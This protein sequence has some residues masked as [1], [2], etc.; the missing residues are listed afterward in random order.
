M[1]KFDYSDNGFTSFFKNNLTSVVT[2]IGVFVTLSLG[3][4]TYL[5]DRTTIKIAQQKERPLACIWY[6]DNTDSA[7]V[8]LENKGIGPMIINKYYLEDLTNSKIRLNGIYDVFRKY[9]KAIHYHTG[10]QNNSV[11]YPKERIKLFFLDK[12]DVDLDTLILNAL[13][14]EL[15]LYKVVIEYSDV[16]DNNMPTYERSLEW[17]GRNYRVPKYE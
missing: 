1:G 5:K 13:K 15:A 9:R 4:I 6:R 7:I 12:N 14:R 10:N 17:F 2:L 8:F 3:L 16:Y 11:L